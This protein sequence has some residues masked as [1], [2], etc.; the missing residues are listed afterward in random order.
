MQRQRRRPGVPGRFVP[1]K[2]IYVNRVALATNRRFEGR[3]L[4]DIATE[5]GK[6][7][8][9]V[10]LDLALE[11]QLETEFQLRTRSAEEDVAL[12]EFV[13]EVG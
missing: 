7:V 11:E 10:M 3:R 12:A 1:W 8:A 4:E 5:T 9:D 2:S 13:V 6:H